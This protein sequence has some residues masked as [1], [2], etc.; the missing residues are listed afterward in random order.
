MVTFHCMA[1]HQRTDINSDKAQGVALYKNI[2]LFS[3]FGCHLEDLKHGIQI[4][5]ATGQTYVNA[6]TVVG[7]VFG[8]IQNGGIAAGTNAAIG[9]LTAIGNRFSPN[10]IPF[11][12]TPNVHN[13]V[14]VGGNSPSA[15]TQANYPST[16]YVEVSPT[17]PPGTINKLA[18]RVSSFTNSS[19]PDPTTVLPGTIIYNTDT[20]QLNIMENGVWQAV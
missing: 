6:L 20:N 8:T 2:D 3:M 14:M 19:R 12:D 9:S 11:L 13:G 16:G 5:R 1:G 7:C 17:S 18:F 10:N 15:S 4:W